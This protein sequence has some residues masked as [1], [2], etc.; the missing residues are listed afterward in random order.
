MVERADKV[1]SRLISG[2]PSLQDGVND[3][4]KGSECSKVSCVGG[5]LWKWKS[6]S[7]LENVGALLE[8]ENTAVKQ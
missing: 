2:M 1:L 7:M 8:I 3:S 6:E 4:L 5:L